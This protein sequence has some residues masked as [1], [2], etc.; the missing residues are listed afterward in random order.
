MQQLDSES[1]RRVRLIL[2]AEEVTITLPNTT[3]DVGKLLSNVHK[4][5][6]ELARDNLRIILSSIK[7]LASQGLALLG[8]DDVTESI[9]MQLLELRTKDNPNL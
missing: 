4:G 3:T 2:E 5:E 6:K 7:Y 1:T 9:L 8:G